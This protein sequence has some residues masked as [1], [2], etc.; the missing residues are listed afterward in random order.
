MHSDKKLHPEYVLLFDHPNN[1]TIHEASKQK[2]VEISQQLFKI[3]KGVSSKSS[4]MI[5]LTSK[6]KWE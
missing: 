4:R 5:H 2:K 3:L 1:L 6:I